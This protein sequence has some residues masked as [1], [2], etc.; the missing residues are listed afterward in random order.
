MSRVPRESTS[1]QLRLLQ[2]PLVLEVFLVDI[3]TC[4]CLEKSLWYLGTASLSPKL[5]EDNPS[6][7]AQGYPVKVQVC[8]IDYSIDII[9]ARR[10]FSTKIKFNVEQP[11]H[12]RYISR[13]LSTWQYSIAIQ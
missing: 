5:R 10:K 9:Y 12:Q 4:C 2:D 13:V 8:N 7:S 1:T 11:G 6:C 3:L